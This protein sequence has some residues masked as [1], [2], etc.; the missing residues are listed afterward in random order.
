[1]SGGIDLSTDKESATVGGEAI[2]TIGRWRHPKGVSW[3]WTGNWSRLSWR[4][5]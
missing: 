5:H 1:M 4:L 3:R 2:F